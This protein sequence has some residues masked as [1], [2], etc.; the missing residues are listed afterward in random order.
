[1]TPT[2]TRRSSMT[3]EIIDAFEVEL[4]RF[5]GP[6]DFVPLPD[7]VAILSRVVA[8]VI[9]GLPADAAE[10]LVDRLAA[11]LMDRYRRLLN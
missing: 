5:P 2:P 11:L 8:K 3:E 7:I 6:D 9:P 4:Q 1:M 10:E